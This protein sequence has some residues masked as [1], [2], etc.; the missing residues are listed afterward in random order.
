MYRCELSLL[1]D[2]RHIVM[3]CPFYE[4]KRIEMYDEIAKMECEEINEAIA[5]PQ[6]VFHMIL[7]KQPDNVSTFN[8]LR[9]CSITG[10]HIAGIYDCVLVR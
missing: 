2:T 6:N 9:L 10:K 7:G 5:I 8:M 4:N 1:E 3:Q